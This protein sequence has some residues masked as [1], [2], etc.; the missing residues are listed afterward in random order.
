MFMAFISWWY[1]AGWRQQAELLVKR[2]LKVVD[3]FSIDLLLKTLFMPF[4][5]ISADQIDGSLS[6]KMHAMLDKF[7]SRIIGAIVR[8]ITII[9]GVLVLTGYVVI[10]AII[11]LLWP[12]IPFVPFIGLAFAVT[13]W[14]PW[15]Q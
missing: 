4:R 1:G 13:G 10:G 14:T 7:V 15:I 12:V 2:L 11:L 9:T 8:M 5:Q 3:M 6:I